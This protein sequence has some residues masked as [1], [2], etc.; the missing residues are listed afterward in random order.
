MYASAQDDVTASVLQTALLQQ[1]ERF[2]M[3]TPAPRRF[4]KPLMAPGAVMGFK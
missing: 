2:S 3:L 1:R 4:I